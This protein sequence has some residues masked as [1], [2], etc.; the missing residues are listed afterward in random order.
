MK[1]RQ[2]SFGSLHFGFNRLPADRATQC[3]GTVRDLTDPKLVQNHP[4]I[5]AHVAARTLAEAERC[6]LDYFGRIPA[7][8]FD[9]PFASLSD[10][11]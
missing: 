5:A 8:V 7:A 1:K 3:S 9:I 4:P 11:R 6:A 10:A 2:Q